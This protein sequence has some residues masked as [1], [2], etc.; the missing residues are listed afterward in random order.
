MAISLVFEDESVNSSL[1]PL[2]QKSTKSLNVG[3]GLLG[4]VN[5]VVQR[6]EKIRAGS[7]TFRRS[8][9]YVV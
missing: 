2:I 7:L 6:A 9:C 4:G 5:G 3:C 8:F 1:P